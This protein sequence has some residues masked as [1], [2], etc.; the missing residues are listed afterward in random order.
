MTETTQNLQRVEAAM[1][2]MRRA[3]TGAKERLD[4]GL[5]L[6]RTQF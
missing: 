6:T 5:Q 2:A 3:I 1:D 4:E